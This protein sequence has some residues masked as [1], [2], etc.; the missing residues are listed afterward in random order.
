MKNKVPVE[1]LVP[2]LEEKLHVK[3]ESLKNN[4]GEVVRKGITELAIDPKD[5]MCVLAKISSIA[6]DRSGEVVIP[7]GVQV[8]EYKANPVICFQHDYSILPV[9]RAEAIEIT[10]DAVYAKIRFGST[11]RCKEIWSLVK[12]KILSAL[13]I[14]FVTLE[15][16]KKGT[17]EFNDYAKARLMDLG[18]KINDVETIITK[19]TLLETSLVLIPCNQ[20]ALIEYISTKGLSNELK[21][22]MN[23]KEGDVGEDKPETVETVEAEKP[24]EAVEAVEEVVEDKVLHKEGDENCECPECQERRSAYKEQVEAPENG[25]S[26]PEEAFSGD[27]QP[28]KPEDIP[29]ITGDI[30]G[31]IKEIK[32]V[33]QEVVEVKSFFKVIGKVEKKESLEDIV[34]KQ[35]E[36]EMLKRKGRISR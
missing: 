28:T 6:P 29:E 16:L 25:N 13:S 9:G 3:F 35:V 20:E 24:V 5:E 36:I 31:D 26:T 19:C 22:E 18:E 14:G 8:E 17:R 11:D 23:I 32:E 33:I 30:K 4:K 15:T 7:E 12:D 27:T 1:K 2:F 34:K 10:K 21:K